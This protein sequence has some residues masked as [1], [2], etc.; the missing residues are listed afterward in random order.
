M[1][2]DIVVVG[3]SAGGVEPLQVLVGD[4]RQDFA[5]AVFICCH[6]P[7]DGPMLLAKVL[8]KGA[9]LRVSYAVDGA[10][11][12]PGTVQL[13]P[14][15]LHLMLENDRVR[16][17]RGPKQNRARPAIDPLFR[18]AAQSF[19][20]RVIG[21]VL[22]GML[23]DGAAGMLAIKRQHGIAIVQDPADAVCRSM[24]DAASAATKI[25]YC[26]P[27]AGMGALLAR[28]TR[29]TLDEEPRA[30]PDRLDLEK[31]ADT[32][33]IVPMEQLGKASA[34]TCPECAGVL[35]EVDDPELL[36]FRC[37]VGHAFSVGGLALEQ[38]KLSEDALWAAARAL[39]ESASFSRRL[40][41][42]LRRQEFHVAAD[43]Y[44]RR[45]ER[46]ETHAATI[47]RAILHMPVE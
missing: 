33:E 28:L 40:S 26:V 34:Y 37:R 21:V 44:D 35:W 17:S 25:D 2:R 29:E 12:E 7:A 30:P 31:R 46:A 42:R 16:L 47:T 32:G 9:G 41:E 22:S 43:E 15:D 45:A 14:P 11:I 39:E 13:A 27:V 18:S 20:P 3:A 23:D 8:G 4:L 10:P 19:G 24:P 38:K 1:K 6:T 36:R 5:A